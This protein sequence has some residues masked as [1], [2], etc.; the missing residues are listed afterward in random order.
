MK[1]NADFAAFWVCRGGRSRAPVVVDVSLFV[2]IRRAEEDPE[3]L[4]SRSNT[5]APGYQ[6]NRLMDALGIDVIPVTAE[7]RGQGIDRIHFLSFMTLL[8][9]AL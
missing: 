3:A 8:M 9:S 5:I 2:A 7:Q 4:E 6:Q 1:S